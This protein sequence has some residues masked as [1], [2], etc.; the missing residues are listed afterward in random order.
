MV[1]ALAADSGQPGDIGPDARTELPDDLT[2]P[3]AEVLALIAEGLTNAEIAERL[4]ISLS[5][6]KTHVSSVISKLGA[7]SRTEAAT[8]AVR[9]RLV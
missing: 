6:V 4:V 9:H 8:L 3:E 5:T 7:A 1:A 2:P